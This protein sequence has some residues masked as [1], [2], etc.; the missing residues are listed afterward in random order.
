MVW[1][2]TVVAKIP[3]KKYAGERAKSLI[4]PFMIKGI[5]T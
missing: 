3:A 2:E 5:K 1:A 4:A